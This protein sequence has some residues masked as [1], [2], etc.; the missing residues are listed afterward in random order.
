MEKL[1][2]YAKSILIPVII[3]GIV[4][5]LISNYIDSVS[6]THLVSLVQ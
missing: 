3:G 4:G 2:I 1:K 6:Y 5:I